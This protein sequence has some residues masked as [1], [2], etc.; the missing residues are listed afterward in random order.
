LLGNGCS[1]ASCVTDVDD[2]TFTY[3]ISLEL[4]ELYDIAGNNLV[5]WQ[6]NPIYGMD[7]AIKFKIY[8]FTITVS[9]SNHQ[10]TGNGIETC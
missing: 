6:N 2:N 8:L 5:V 3:T 1:G 9:D 10:G 7:G 4:D